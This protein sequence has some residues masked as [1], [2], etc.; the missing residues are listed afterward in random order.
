MVALFSFP[1]ISAILLDS[2]TQSDLSRWS[3]DRTAREILPMICVVG[4]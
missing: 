3:I 4:C 2:E 1:R